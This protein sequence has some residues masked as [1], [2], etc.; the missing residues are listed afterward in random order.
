MKKLRFI[1]VVLVIF[2]FPLK[3]HAWGQQG[4]RIVGQIAESYL[5]P[6]AR[7]AVKDILG[8]ASLAMSAN[9]ADFI[10]SDTNYRYLSSW[11]YLDFPDSMSY[12][13]VKDFMNTDTAA[14]VYSKTNWLVKQL[15]N[16]KLAK[17]KQVFY[18]RL[19]IHF[20][21]DI[22]QPL[23]H[24]RETDQGGNK[25]KVT[26]FG[27]STNL[28]TVWDSK[29]IDLQQLSYTEYSNAV[30]FTKSSQRAK[31][32]KQP[33]S[34]WIYE[35]YVISR[36]IYKDVPQDGKLSY[37]YNFKWISTVEQQLLKGGV[38]LAGLLNEIFK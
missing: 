21:G 24:G 28:H 23:H 31:W 13:Q 5:T 17:D 37:N 30:N 33:V 22:H 12:Q 7:K 38:R 6:K 27:E 19:L 34:E 32:Q 11:H 15:K 26:W 2:I 29:L 4:H 18:L 35:S 20:I 25:V 14:N 36:D 9:W 8:H 1:P 3:S 16:K 10:K